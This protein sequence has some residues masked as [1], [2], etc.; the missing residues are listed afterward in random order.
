MRA[1]ELDRIITIQTPTKTT[2][3]ED[4]P[5]V[6][7]DNFATVH[8]KVT[9]AASMERYRG[10]QNVLTD[11]RVAKIYYLDGVTSE[12]QFIYN[13][14]A[15]EIIADP[16]ELGRREAMELLGRNVDSSG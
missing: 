15:Y 5:I 3:S 4:T 13:G 9:P 16:R 10:Q 8:A 11:D 14:L 1:G 7:W 6:T 12:M 2:D